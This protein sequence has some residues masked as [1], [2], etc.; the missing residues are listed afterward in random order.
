[1]SF[2]L[3]HETGSHL[4]I[5]N[6]HKQTKTSD[7]KT[8]DNRQQK[9]PTRHLQTL[10]CG[11]F[12]FC[13]KK[14]VKAVC[15][16]FFASDSERPREAPEEGYSGEAQGGACLGPRDLARGASGDALGV[17]KDPMFPGAEAFGS[18]RK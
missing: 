3:P 4:L 13:Q 6:Q 11:A 18:Q 2:I 15:C 1:M 12:P 5:S 17:G 14:N 16:C 8:T 10:Q 7:N 9:S